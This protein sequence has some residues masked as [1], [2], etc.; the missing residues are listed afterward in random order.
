MER[1]QVVNMLKVWKGQLLFVMIYLVYVIYN[2]TTFVL[3]IENVNYA[4]VKGLN[5][6]S[7]VRWY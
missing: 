3:Y 6:A 4:L 2:D 7:R 5:H 1:V